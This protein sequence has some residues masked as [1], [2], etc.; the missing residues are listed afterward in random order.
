[1][2]DAPLDIVSATVNGQ[3]RSVRLK[4]LVG[5]GSRVLVTDPDHDMHA[6]NGDDA[7]ELRP[8]LVAVIQVRDIA[9]EDTQKFALWLRSKPT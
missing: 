9:P 4:R 5:D 8:T 3:I 7:G 1:V 2:A 6:T